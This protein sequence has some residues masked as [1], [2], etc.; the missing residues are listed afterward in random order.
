VYIAKK[1]LARAISL[2]VITATVLLTS[3]LSQS[4]VQNWARGDSTEEQQSFAHRDYLY[5]TYAP[6]IEWFGRSPMYGNGGNNAQSTDSALLQLGLGF[7]WIV[8]AAALIPLIIS[9][10]RV[11]TGRAS[12]AEIAVVGQIPLFTTVALITQYESI[13]FLVVGIAVTMQ[14][15]SQPAPEGHLHDAAPGT[16]RLPPAELQDLDATVPR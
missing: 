9:V 4:L 5:S 10:I 6:S 15:T 8:L 7:G 14:V 16:K 12:T 11:A 13:I 1:P 3:P 2:T